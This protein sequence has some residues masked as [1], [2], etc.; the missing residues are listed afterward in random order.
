MQRTRGAQDWTTNYCA[1][2][3]SQ[4]Q[5]PNCSCSALPSLLGA[6]L[7]SKR[8]KDYVAQEHHNADCGEERPELLSKLLQD[9]AIQGR[10]QE[11]ATRI[12]PKSLAHNAQRIIDEASHAQQA[13]NRPAEY[14]KQQAV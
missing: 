3:F 12:L 8:H 9:E 4:S 1:L 2:R 5:E 10:G 7:A 13:H 6:L 14:H 11:F